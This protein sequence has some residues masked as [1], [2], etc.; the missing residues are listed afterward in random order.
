MAYL[1]LINNPLDD[2]SLRRII[3]IP[4]RSIGDVTVSK[5][6]DFSEEISECM[7][8]TLLDV[9]QIPGLS[10]RNV[11]SLNKFVSLVNSFI[12]RRDEVS[13]SSILKII[14]EDTGYIKNL[15]DSKN[16]KI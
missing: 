3:N 13:V 14:L 4:K 7:Y 9:E 10:A 2:V 12:R 15:Q 16:P 6:H 8:S 5:I 11:T 1:K